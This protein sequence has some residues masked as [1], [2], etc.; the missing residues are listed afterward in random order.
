MSNDT[1]FMKDSVAVSI[2]AKCFLCVPD[3]PLVIAQPKEIKNIGRTDV[4]TET[5]ILWPPDVKS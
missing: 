3:K 2:N 5:P 4:E 1:V